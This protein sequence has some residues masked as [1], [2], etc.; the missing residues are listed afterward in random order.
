MFANKHLIAAMLV[1]P[2]LAIIAYLAVDRVVRER[3][4]AAAP[5]A[6]YKLAER[7]D[8][9]YQSGHCTLHNGD[10]E[11]QLATRS[12]Q[13]GGL[14][15]VVASAIPLDGIKVAIVSAR[16]DQDTPRA[17]LPDGGQRTQWRLPLPVAMAADSRILLV[18]AVHDSYYYGDTATTFTVY[19]TTFDKDFR[20]QPAP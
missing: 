12:L 16:Q 1:A 3:P 20:R 5:G 6:S 18:A 19:R 15:L 8:C 10:M 4:S 11:L 9:R 14:E 13:G 2:I 17:M 7:S